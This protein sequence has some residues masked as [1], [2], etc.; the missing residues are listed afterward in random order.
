[1]STLATKTE[2]GRTVRLQADFDSSAEFQWPDPRARTKLNRC[3]LVCE[4]RIG[5][6]EILTC[7]LHVLAGLRSGLPEAGYLLDCLV[8]YALT[9]TFAPQAVPL[10]L[11][12]AKQVFKT[13]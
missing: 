1:M 2:I 13:Q 9:D 6:G 7:S 12:K 8:D 10:T 5:R 11:E 4:G 3:G